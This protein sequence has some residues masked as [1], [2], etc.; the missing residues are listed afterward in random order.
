MRWLELVTDP[1]L[2]KKDGFPETET[3]LLKLHRVLF[4]LLSGGA[5]SLRIAGPRFSP[6][7]GP[8]SMNLAIGPLTLPFVARSMTNRWALVDG[9][10]T[11]SCSCCQSVTDTNLRY[12]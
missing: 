7:V 10:A 1:E 6:Y 9:D 5:A 8:S 3:E 4:E 2:K 11:S 12:K